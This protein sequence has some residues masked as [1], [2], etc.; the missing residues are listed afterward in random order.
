MSLPFFNVEVQ[1]QGLPI[2]T[3]FLETIL[4]QAAAMALIMIGLAILTPQP[5]DARGLY[6]QIYHNMHSLLVQ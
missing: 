4:F 5:H 2:R 3:S 1:V 6:C